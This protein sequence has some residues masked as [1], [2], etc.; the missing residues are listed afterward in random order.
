[1][2]SVAAVLT[3][4][5]RRRKTIRALAVKDT[6]PAVLTRIQNVYAHLAVTG[7]YVGQLES[8]VATYNLKAVVTA[9]QRG[10]GGIAKQVVKA[11]AIFSFHG[12]T[13]LLDSA[14]LISKGKDAEAVKHLFRELLD[15]GI[16]IGVKLTPLHYVK[17]I[18]EAF[19]AF[20]D[21]LRTTK[22]TR[23]RSQQ[24]KVGNDVLYWLD[25]VALVMRCWCYA[26]ELFLLGLQGKGATPEDQIWDLVDA[27]VVAEAKAWQ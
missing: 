10:G 19:E 26:A 12:F 20:R 25:G 6:H 14:D 18:A 8:A 1:M 2:P 7:D 27:K 22:A 4:L 15:M 16:K 23:F 17:D 13:A 3:R 21:I 5:S 11:S 24:V 9:K